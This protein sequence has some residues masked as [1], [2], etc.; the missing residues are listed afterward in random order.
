MSQRSCVLCGR[1]LT[2]AASIE[3]GIGPTCRQRSND[4][5]A[6]TIPCDLARAQSVVAATRAI[7]E[8]AP[9]VVA[10]TLRA[11]L[12]D[13]QRAPMGEMQDWR[14]TIKRFDWVLSHHE[15]KV[16]M[17]EAIYGIARALGYVGTVA[18][19][20]KVPII[21][22]RVAYEKAH[23]ILISEPPHRVVLDELHELQGKFNRNK[24]WSIPA[25][26]ADRL[27]AVLT[28]YFD[29]SADALASVLAQARAHME[30]AL[31]EEHPLA[32]AAASHPLDSSTRSTV[33]RARV[34]RTPNELIIQAHYNDKF[35][36]ALRRIVPRD[37]RKWIN[38]A[39][40]WHI[41]PSYD[42]AVIEA[43]HAAFG[44]QNVD[45]C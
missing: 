8:N 36:A 13:V 43:L 6:R 40:E 32:V 12:S 45:V 5:L 17:R 30:P 34:L 7:F 39:R 4:A 26:H 20:R 14:V 19:W 23:I 2:D 22:A 1:P 41:T 18:L 15:V 38:D 37:D 33:R 28:A 21:Q 25:R 10:P 16:P 24:T 29:V 27:G 9:E 35:L 44:A 31:A 11:A 42:G 3:A